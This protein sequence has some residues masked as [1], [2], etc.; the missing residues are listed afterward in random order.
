MAITGGN[1]KP[2][3]TTGATATKNTRRSVPGSKCSTSVRAAE[4]CLSRALSR[5]SVLLASI[6]PFSRLFLERWGFAARAARP[7]NSRTAPHKSAANPY[8]RDRS[9]HQDKYPVVSHQVLVDYHRGG[10]RGERYESSPGSVVCRVPKR[11]WP[12]ATRV[13]PEVAEEEAHGD[14]RAHKQGQ[15]DQPVPRRMVEGGEED[16][17]HVPGGVDEPDQH[18]SPCPTH[19]QELGE[20]VASPS[21]LFAQ[22]QSEFEQD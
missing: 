22:G 15:H 5:L 18:Q 3:T 6:L 12:H 20:Q 14:D 21:Y 17:G 9:T 7:W 13:D 4:C 16:Q 2:L 11:G 8:G 10:S 1:P 19:A